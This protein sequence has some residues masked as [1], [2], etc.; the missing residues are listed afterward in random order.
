MLRARATPETGTV[1]YGVKVA[2]AGDLENSVSGRRRPSLGWSALTKL[3][4]LTRAR[5]AAPLPASSDADRPAPAGTAV[6]G[7]RRHFFLAEL[8]F[9]DSGADDGARAIGADADAGFA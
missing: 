4:A 5:E 7:R 2:I 1:R 9:T 8:L 3:A 6:A